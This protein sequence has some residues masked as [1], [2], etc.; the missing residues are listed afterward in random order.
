M[1]QPCR[2]QEPLCLQRRAKPAA[3]AGRGRLKLLAGAAGSAP[4]APRLQAWVP[5]PE[6]PGQGGEE[7]L[8]WQGSHILSFPTA[9]PG[10][11]GETGGAR[12][13]AAESENF[14]LPEPA[15]GC[16]L[17]RGSASFPNLPSLW[18]RGGKLCAE[19]I[20]S[21]SILRLSVKNPTKPAFEKGKDEKCYT[22]GCFQRNLL[23]LG[24]LHPRKISIRPRFPL[25][26]SFYLVITFA[27]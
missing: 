23:L 22:L 15:A 18:K 14:P 21:P 3:E 10:I 8:A 12:Q 19:K 6:Q 27:F 4:P 24:P 2:C 26:L 16:H 11:A 20:A 9:G 13:P 5:E 1:L 17:G 7:L 25:V